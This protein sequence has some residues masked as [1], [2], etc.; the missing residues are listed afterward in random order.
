[1]PR[2]KTVEQL[3]AEIAALKAKRHAA[4]VAESRAER[5]AR[6]HA[7]IVLGGMIEACYPDGWRSVDYERVSR[8][9]EKSRD[10]FAK[11]CWDTL[12]TP[13][14]TARLRDWERGQRA[15]SSDN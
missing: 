7:L 9:V 1:M 2:K 10:A 3:D 4:V 15:K 14:A 5:K 13:E 12:P 8:A 6:D 11:M